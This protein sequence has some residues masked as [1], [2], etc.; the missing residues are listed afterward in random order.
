MA[1]SWTRTL[2][3]VVA[4]T[5]ELFATAPPVLVHFHV[6]FDMDLF[7][8]ELLQVLSA[9]HPRS[10]QG[11]P[12][13]ADDDPLLGVPFDHDHG[14]YPDNFLVSQEFLGFH[15]HRIGDFLFVM[16]QDLFPNGLVDK[17][18]F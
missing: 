9:F 15:F 8:K 12:L 16:E 13:M 3:T 7:V 6:E 18:P 1:A 2:L 10:F 11:G 5:F 17:K 14:P 4:K